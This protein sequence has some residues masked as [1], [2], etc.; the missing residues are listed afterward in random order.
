MLLEEMEAQMEALKKL[1][2]DKE[3][4]ISKSKK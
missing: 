1:L 2:K 4:E 3:D